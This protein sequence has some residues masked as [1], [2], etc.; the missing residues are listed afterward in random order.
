MSNDA[1]DFARPH[2]LTTR[3][4]MLRPEARNASQSAG[5][6]TVSYG[7][8]DGML[9]EFYEDP[10]FMEYLSKQVG[11]PIYRM[12]IMTR[13][14]Q[15][16]NTKTVWCHQT[17]G[18]EY[19]MV[20]D[21]ESREYHTNW[22]IQ[23]VCD[24]GDVPEPVKYPNA[25]NK[26]MRK[27]ISADTGHPIEEWGTV[28]RSYAMSL[29][30]MHVHTVEA[31]ASLSDIQA[32]NIMGAI[33]YRDLAKAYLDD[34]VK[35]EIVAREQEKAAR[36]EEQCANQARQIEALQQHVLALQ[37]RLNGGEG[38]A[39]AGGR[40]IESTEVGSQLGKYNEAERTRQMSTSDA[41]KRHKI[42]VADPK[43]AA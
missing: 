5:N 10:E 37:S 6:M 35:T 20:I 36:Y 32:Q 41:R 11:H 9:V 43:A 38:A 30:A 28:S 18:I 4:T 19:E 15:P 34:R 1:P 26:F 40:L 3:E 31:L 7:L 2:H 23:E 29:K 16:G 33:K 25:W 22:D 13:I 24:N 27:G 8:D 17:K 42:P 21:P 14:I 12:R 39:P